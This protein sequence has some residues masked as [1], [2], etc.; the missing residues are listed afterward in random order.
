MTNVER[1]VNETIDLLSGHKM[2][3]EHVVAHMVRRH[4]T[5]K[6]IAKSTVKVN[7]KSKAK[8]P[9]RPSVK[10]YKAFTETNGNSTESTPYTGISEADFVSQ[11]LRRVRAVGDT[12]AITVPEAAH[13]L[14]TTP[15]AITR[16]I[17]KRGT[18]ASSADLPFSKNKANR[19]VTDGHS[20]LKWAERRSSEG[21]VQ[22]ALPA[23]VFNVAHMHVR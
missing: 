19:W 10:P 1:I 5:T 3:K 2:T 15:K 7:V 11:I 13:V 21:R 17:E 4:G 14:G 18:V 6:T 8:R 20:L 9:A 16:F 23:N 22:W 12:K